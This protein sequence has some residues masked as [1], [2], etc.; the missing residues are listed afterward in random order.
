M[1]DEDFYQR[2]ASARDGEEK[3]ITVSRS[4]LRSRCK[5]HIYNLNRHAIRFTTPARDRH[6]NAS[7]RG[8]RSSSRRWGI[9]I[10][11]LLKGRSERLGINTASTASRCV[12]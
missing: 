12:P 4:E 11:T 8:G 9:R 7:K 3:D 2:H 10:C 1:V 6:T 5:K